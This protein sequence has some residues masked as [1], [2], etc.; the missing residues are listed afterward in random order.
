MMMKKVYITP[1]TEFTIHTLNV[2][3][4]ACSGEGLEQDQNDNGGTC[5]KG[6]YDWWL[7]GDASDASAQE[8]AWDRF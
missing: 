5:A 8:N 4:L 6:H 1:K 7:D 3:I 2:N